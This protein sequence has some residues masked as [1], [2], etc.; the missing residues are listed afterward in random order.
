MRTE[1]DSPG[2]A[3]IHHLTDENVGFTDFLV[4]TPRQNYCRTPGAYRALPLA[5]LL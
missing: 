3:D 4:N 1:I 2:L 5:E